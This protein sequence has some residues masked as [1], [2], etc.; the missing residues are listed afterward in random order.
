MKHKRRT[1]LSIGKLPG[2]Y[3]PSY[4]IYTI[5]KRNKASFVLRTFMTFGKTTEGRHTKDYKSLLRNLLGSSLQKR[6]RFLFGWAVGENYCSAG[7][8][9]VEITAVRVRCNETFT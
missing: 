8:A 4:I 6:M 2:R 1:Y 5:M 7:R 9:G 3:F